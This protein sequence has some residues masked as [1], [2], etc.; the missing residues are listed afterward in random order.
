MP[1]NYNALCRF[2]GRC[3]SAGEWS[4]AIQSKLGCVCAR[5]CV[6]VCVCVCVR[7][8]YVRGRGRRVTGCGEWEGA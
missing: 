3:H 6:C 4:A 2:F 5:V 1:G 8:E 7:D